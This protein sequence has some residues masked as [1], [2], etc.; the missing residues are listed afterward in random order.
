[1]IV[2]VGASYG[3]VTD[4]AV[5]LCGCVSLTVDGSLGPM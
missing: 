2:T 5:W 1:M 3:R 4:C